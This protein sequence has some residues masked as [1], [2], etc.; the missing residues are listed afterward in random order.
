MA[1]LQKK[2]QTNNNICF[3]K[4]NL[5]SCDCNEEKFC[6]DKQ[7]SENIGDNIIAAKELLGVS[8]NDFFYADNTLEDFFRKIALS[9]YLD[10]KEKLSFVVIGYDNIDFSDIEDMANINRIKTEKNG[11]FDYNHF[12]DVVSKDNIDFIVFSCVNKPLGVMQDIDDVTSLASKKDIPIAVDVTDVIGIAN[13]KFSELKADYWVFSLASSNPTMEF[14]YLFAKNNQKLSSKAFGESYINQKFQKENILSKY[15][16]NIAVLGEFCSKVINSIDK[17][18]IAT[19]R[20]RDFFEEE[21]AKKAEDVIFFCKNACRLP[22]ISIFG[23]D[24]CYNEALIHRLYHKGVFIDLKASSDTTNILRNSNMEAKNII[25][26]P[27]NIYFNASMTEEMVLFVIDII[28][29]EKEKIKAI[30]QGGA[31]S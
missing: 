31:I 20:I 10:K 13:I 9:L 14:S 18:V 24:R 27:I 29:E 1:S 12:E 17:E 28:I 7:I 11:C 15:F 5:F 30:S 19:T 3:Y 25:N 8:A 23:F 2:Y 16:L 6:C 26:L 22:G 4:N 21:I